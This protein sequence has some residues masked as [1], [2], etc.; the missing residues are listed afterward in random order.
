MEL[1]NINWLNN[2]LDFLIINQRFEEAAYFRSVIRYD[3]N[4]YS[5]LPPFNSTTLPESVFD[6]GSYN[7]FLKSEF[8]EDFYSEVHMSYIDKEFKYSFPYEVSVLYLRNSK[9]NEILL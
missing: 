4:N 7:I 1:T 2:C 9:I 3:P 6:V 5:I 8:D